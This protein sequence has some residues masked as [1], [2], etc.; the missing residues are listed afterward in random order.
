[1]KFFGKGSK[2]NS[3]LRMRCP[4]CQSAPLFRDGNPYNFS[5]FFDMHERCPKCNLNFFPEEGFYY[6]AMFA[7]YF[8][9]AGILFGLAALLILFTGSVTTV[10]M[11]LFVA[12]ILF[13]WPIIF[14]ISRAIWINFFE[15][16]DKNAI[17]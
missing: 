16:Y 6:G 7:S 11:L 9:T 3:V 8:V 17:Q 12:I 2:L 15:S 10:Q 1:M 14:R 4:K 13:L 5:R